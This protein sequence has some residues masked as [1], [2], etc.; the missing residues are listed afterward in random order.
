MVLECV[1]YYVC[2]MNVYMLGIEL[3]NR[4]CYLDWFDSCY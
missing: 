3:V 4:G 1:V 2:G